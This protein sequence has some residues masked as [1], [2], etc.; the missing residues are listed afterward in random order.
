MGFS[1]VGFMDSKRAMML[2][3]SPS[4]CTH[5]RMHNS[6]FVEVF[7]IVLIIVDPRDLENVSSVVSGLYRVSTNGDT[8]AVIPITENTQ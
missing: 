6:E 5:D 3:T 8:I 7:C 1:I 4:L 2:R